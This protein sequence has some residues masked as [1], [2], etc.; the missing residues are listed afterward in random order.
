MSYKLSLEEIENGFIVTRPVERE[1]QFIGSK[2]WRETIQDAI[3]ECE[4][5][6]K[7]LRA[8]AEKQEKEEKQ[9]KPRKNP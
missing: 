7:S 2:V 3:T 4:V 9:G 1:N 6:L 8:E 5:A